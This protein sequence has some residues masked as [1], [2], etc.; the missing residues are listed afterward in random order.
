ML[1]V[2]QTVVY[3]HFELRYL[4]KRNADTWLLLMVMFID[5]GRAA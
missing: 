4:I 2:L 1:E 3:N 5:L